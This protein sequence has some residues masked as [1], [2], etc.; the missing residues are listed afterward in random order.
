M[1][2]WISI[3]VLKEILNYIVARMNTWIMYEEQ[4]KNQNAAFIEL[5]NNLKEETLK[6]YRSS[7]FFLN[8]TTEELDKMID[9]YAPI[10]KKIGD[11]EYEKKKYLF[12]EE[13]EFGK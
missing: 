10:A 9:K 4:E 2:H 12:F 3:D 5:C 6:L 1:W 13:T 8:S 7:S 11:F